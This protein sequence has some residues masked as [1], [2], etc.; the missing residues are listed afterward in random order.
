[1]AKPK[2]LRSIE[3]I[4]AEISILMDELKVREE[5][6]NLRIAAIVR[7]SGIGSLGLSD[8]QLRTAL[9]QITHSFR[10]SDDGSNCDLEK[11]T[12]VVADPATTEISP[13]DN[14]SNENG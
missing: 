12:K 5:Q 3:T 2:K 9:E 13:R 14:S 8:N 10:K 4:N 6:E 7:A 11:A 1:M